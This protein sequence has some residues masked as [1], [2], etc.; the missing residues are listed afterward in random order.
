MKTYWGSGC[1]APRIFNL[2]ISW[3]WIVSF[4]PR[5]LYPRDKSSRFPLDRRLGGPQRLS[6]CA[7]EEKNSHHYPTGNWTP[8]VQPVAKSLYWL[9][10]SGSSYFRYV[11]KFLN[12][13]T[14]LLLKHTNWESS[15]KVGGLGTGRA[16]IGSWQWQESYIQYHI[17]SGSW[18]PTTCGYQRHVKSVNHLDLVEPW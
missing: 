16:G 6:G 17:Q 14:F 15:V 12:R 8:V 4:T 7:G 3:R 5:P 10:Y 1:I 11:F 9:S 18:V 13:L 2:G